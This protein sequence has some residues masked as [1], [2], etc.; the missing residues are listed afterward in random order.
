MTDSQMTQKMFNSMG[1][2][3][4]IL[5]YYEK[6]AKSGL[7]FSTSCPVTIDWNLVAFI[8]FSLFSVIEIVSNLFITLGFLTYNI[9]QLN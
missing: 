1:T 5:H 9:L 3:K 2:I 8:N 7:V 4:N 6:R